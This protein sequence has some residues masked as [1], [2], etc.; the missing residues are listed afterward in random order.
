MGV[1]E[2]AAF[3]P[4]A[5]QSA[6]EYCHPRLLVSSKAHIGG[7][8]FHG[9]G[10]D[11]REDT[12]SRLQR[13]QRICSDEKG[14]TPANPLNSIGS[15]WR[16]D[17]EQKDSWIKYNNKGK[18][19]S[20]YGQLN[21]FF[22]IQHDNDA[23]FH[24][25]NFA[26]VTERKI[27][28]FGFGNSLDAVPLS[29]LENYSRTPRILFLILKTVDVSVVTH[30][31]IGGTY[32]PTTKSWSPALKPYLVNGLPKRFKGKEGTNEENDGAEEKEEKK[33]KDKKNTIN[34]SFCTDANQVQ[35]LL[36]IPL[37]A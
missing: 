12:E 18:K 29:S 33:E 36:L 6:E 27:T 9:R 28:K 26:S 15:T 20:Y 5:V 4:K 19:N 34:I 11:Y 7:V 2:D 13:G 31:P 3:C 21:A 1:L 16:K 24:N 25:L 17:N 37:D 30:L 10:L 8:Q 22:T 35:F 23:L 32:S 14:H